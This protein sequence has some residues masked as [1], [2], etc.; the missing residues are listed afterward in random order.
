MWSCSS[1]RSACEE[2]TDEGGDACCLVGGVLCDR[3]W[4]RCIRESST[5]PHST[6]LQLTRSDN[7]IMIWF[8]VGALWVF[9]FFFVYQK[10]KSS[11]VSSFSLSW[12]HKKGRKKSEQELFVCGLVCGVGL[13]LCVI[14]VVCVLVEEKK[15]TVSLCLRF[16]LINFLSKHTCAKKK[17]KKGLFSFFAFFCA[18][19]HQQKKSHNFFVLCD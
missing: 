7:S 11:L 17:F 16:L 10:T 19:F 12:Y 6:W 13:L 5:S 14:V 1:W 8:C 9:F 2:Q 15:N 3:F 18:R 4:A